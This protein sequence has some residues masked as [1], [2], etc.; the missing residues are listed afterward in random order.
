MINWPDLVLP[1]LNLYNFPR[2]PNIYK[3]TQM[4]ITLTDQNGTY[5]ISTN[6]SYDTLDE[7]IEMLIKPVLLAATFSPALL[8][9]FF[10]KDW[11]DCATCPYL[12]SMESEVDGFFDWDDK[13]EVAAK[14]AHKEP[15]CKKVAKAAG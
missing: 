3:D 12:G 4:N 10:V 6:E 2:Q 11:Q 15:V 14:V 1:P 13:E 7:Y 8:D 9:K 5:S